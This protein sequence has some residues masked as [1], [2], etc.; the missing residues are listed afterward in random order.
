MHADRSTGNLSENISQ[1]GYTLS[2]FVNSNIKMGLR[3][4]KFFSDGAFFVQGFVGE[5]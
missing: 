2:F 4:C 1:R 3:L 5:I